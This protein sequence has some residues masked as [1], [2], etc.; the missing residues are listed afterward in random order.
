MIEKTVRITGSPYFPPPFRWGYGWPFRRGY[1]GLDPN[2]RARVAFVLETDGFAVPA[3][4]LS[5]QEP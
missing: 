1:R 3:W 5:P 4:L 2:Q